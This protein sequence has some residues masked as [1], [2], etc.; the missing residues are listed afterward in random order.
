MA[1]K[2]EKINT[3]CITT[4]NWILHFPFIAINKK[5]AFLVS[6]NKQLIWSHFWVQVDTCFWL[7]GITFQ[8]KNNALSGWTYDKT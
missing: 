1:V 4:K 2:N 3:Q 8:L 6:C 7:Q 5:S